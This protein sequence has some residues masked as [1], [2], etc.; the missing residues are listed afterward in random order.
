MKKVIFS[1][2]V[3]L[4]SFS[5]FSQYISINAFGGYTFRDKINFGNA[6]AY[7]NAGGIWGASIEGVNMRGTG[8]ELLYQYQSTKIPLYTYPGNVQQNATND[9]AV[10]SYLLLNFEQYYM[11][12]P[13]IEPYGGLGLGAA[14]YKGDFAGSTS[15][16]KFAWDIKAGVKFNTSSSFGIKIGAQLL[17]ST[18]VTGAG[19]Y[20][21]YPGYV[22]PYNT[23][24]TILQFSFTGGLVFSFGGK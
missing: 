8:L 11:N 4:M 13:K 14:F 9:G 20:V 7:L 16:T 18:Q 12:N 23:Y 1:C 10:I 5:A 17:S 24:A 6:Y 15:E 21:G 19:F 2:F 3:L 22:Y